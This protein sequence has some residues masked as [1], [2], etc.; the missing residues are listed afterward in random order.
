MP[1]YLPTDSFT[2]VALIRM[3]NWAVACPP[4]WM[5]GPSHRPHPP[6]AC[7]C[8]IYGIMCSWQSHSIDTLCIAQIIQVN[9]TMLIKAGKNVMIHKATDGHEYHQH[10]VTMG[11]PPPV[12]WKGIT[13]YPMQLPLWT[14]PREIRCNIFRLFDKFASVSVN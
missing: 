2:V 5:P 10:V 9:S 11:D 6:S 7:H 3:K 1:P 14:Y 13:R 4:C 12:H 8:I